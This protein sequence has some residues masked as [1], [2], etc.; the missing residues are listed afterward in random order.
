MFKN[1]SIRAILTTALAVFSR[2]SWSSASPCTS[3]CLPTAIPSKS[4]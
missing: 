1:L 2:F 3:N 4:C